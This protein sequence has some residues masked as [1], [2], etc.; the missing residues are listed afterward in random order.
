MQIRSL[1]ASFLVALGALTASAQLPTSAAADAHG[2]LRLNVVVTAGNRGKPVT[3]LNQS[4]FT[5]LDNGA[6]QRIRSFRAAPAQADPAKVLLVIDDVNTSFER[7]AYE[8]QQLDKYLHANDG[9]LAQPTALAIVTDRTTEVEPGF[10]T[11]GNALSQ[12]LAKQVI[13]L[14]DL[15]RSSGFYGAEERLDISLRALNAI[16]SR[17]AAQ[18]GRKSIVWI[19][20]GWPLLSGPNIQISAKQQQ[21]LFNEVV[22]FS[23]LLRQANVTLYALDPL[24]AGEGPGREFYFEEYLKGVRKPSEAVP[25]ALGAQV[26]AVQ[27]GGLFLS[28]NNDLGVLLQQPYDDA[29]AAYEITYDPPP[30]EG[31]NEYHRVEVRV[32]EPRLVARTRQGY[33]SQP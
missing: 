1:A 16:V 13:G 9:R 7:I 30:S 12:A 3:G 24:G 17:A 10:T 28:S 27:S 22:N 8:R 18:P 25:A 20:P 4:S 31:A 21:S 19:S 32:A 33:Y 14:R 11:D 6:P 23:N 29:L 5:V 2:P 26:L 15:R